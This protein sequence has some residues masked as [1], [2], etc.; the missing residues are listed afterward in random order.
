MILTGYILMFFAANDLFFTATIKMKYY[1][2][3]KKCQKIME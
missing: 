2:L 3:V 1:F